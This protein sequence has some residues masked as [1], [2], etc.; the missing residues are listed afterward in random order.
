MADTH[1]EQPAVDQVSCPA[2]GS[3]N[4]AGFRFCGSCGSAMER[5]CPNCGATSP[6][7][8]RFCGNC[9]TPLTGEAPAVQAR[10]QV[11]PE[12]EERKVVTVLFADLTAS[13]ELAS[14]LDPEDLRGILTPFFEA[15][16]EE[17]TAYGGTIQKFIGDAVVAVFGVPAAHEDDPERAVRAALAMYR[18]LRRV[19]D[20][21][22]SSGRP[23]LQMRI[24][25][26]T[27]EVVTARGIDRE[28]L[29]T[30]EP[31]N[32]AA[33]LETLARPGT[34]FVGD[35]THRDTRHAI[36]YRSLGAV[37]VKGIS[38]PV[39]AWE[40][41]GE[42]EAR[43]AAGPTAAAPMVGRDS[44]LELLRLL[45]SRTIRE[46]R[47]SLA[48]VVG[49]AGIGKSRLGWE[50]MAAVRREAPSVRMVR[51]RC[52]PYGAGLTYWPLAEILKAD[53]GIMDSDP[54]EAI[55][56]K[57]RTRLGERFAGEEPGS[58]TT[59]V[60]L[61]SIGVPVHP[62]PLGGA[63]A[64][65]ARELITKSWRAYFEAVAADHPLVALIEDVHWAD[66]SL[67]DVIESLAGKV[68]APVLFLAMA[69]PDLWERRAGWGGGLR[70]VARIELSPLSEQESEA[71][72]LHLLGDATA[73]PE[74]LRPIMERAEGNPFFAQELLQMLIEEGFLVRNEHA[75][76][77]ERELPVSL[78]DTVQGVIASRID[79]L[80]AAEKRAIQDASVVGRI[81]WRG[82]LERLGTPDPGPVMDALVQKGLAWER[83]G[84]VIEGERELIFNHV[85]TRDVAYQSIPRSRR[86]QAHAQALAWVEEVVRG[87]FDEFAEILAYHAELAGDTARTARY[88]LLA[89]HRSRR[90]F[91]AEEAIGWYDRA[92]EA[93]AALPAE[94]AAPL[95]AELARSRGEAHEQVGRFPEASADYAAA[96]KEARAAGLG[97]EEARGLAALAHVFWLQDRYDE[98][99]PLVE[100]A[101][102]RARAVGATDLLARLLYTAGTMRFG[103]GQ[104]REALGLHQEAVSVAEAGGDREGEAWAR[105]G[106]CETLYFLGPFQDALE[107]GL[108]ADAMLRALGQRPMVFHNEYMISFLNM[109]L[110]RFEEGLRTADSSIVGNRELGNR[111]DETFALAGKGHLLYHVGDLGGSMVLIDQADE[112]AAGLQS[113]R[114]SLGVRGFRAMTLAEIGA[115]DRA[116]LDVEAVAQLHEQIGGNFFRPLSVG[117]RAWMELRAGN[118]E[119]AAVL[120]GQARGYATD[121]NQSLQT[122]HV[123]LLAWEDTA[124][125]DGV[126]EVASRLME[127]DSSRLYAA[128]AEYGAALAAELSGDWKQAVDHAGRAWQSASALGQTPVLWR[129]AALQSRAFRSLGREAETEEARARAAE[130]VRGV[131]DGFQDPEL[132]EAFASRAAIRDLLSPSGTL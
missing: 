65:V 15:M 64:E 84:S 54:P 132:R 14:R 102:E 131:L 118:R 32:L 50:F 124:D 42:A 103:R 2:C 26:N 115:F 33:R 71:L 55:Q 20:E 100:E 46:G 101:L 41:V 18:R 73:P 121:L 52:L 108:R 78:P 38:R 129:S 6:A 72:V 3:P 130:T 28:G 9:A 49:P 91:A 86:A 120:F 29:V 8:F 68:A 4:P 122:A 82:A 57:A 66:Q 44:E 16:V 119:G 93:A 128:W 123:E 34:I 97:D 37:S 89:G 53:A 88:A 126:A 5:T 116:A 87:R 110:G 114:L 77:L 19:N 109:L 7:S 81:F 106:L 58:G 74:A 70:S 90:V 10:P 61:S 27:G 99:E 63:S 104:F 48:T 111:R 43:P 79:L 17:I 95:V 107:E 80:P 98:G 23:E 47:A 35:R 62:D 24:G 39:T 69:R 1:P 105:H 113:P 11:Q 31:V 40:V 125:A 67:L 59:Q 96:V 127:P 13:T 25:V 51:G 85:L 117:L 30:G 75:W 12:L 60:L 22:K 94:E 21:L 76:R 92:L 56:D 83:D 45:L 112:L 36:D